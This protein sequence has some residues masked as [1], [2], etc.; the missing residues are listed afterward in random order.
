MAAE[1]DAGNAGSDCSVKRHSRCLAG[2]Q[3]SHEAASAGKR[4]RSFKKVGMALL[5]LGRSS[6]KSRNS[7]SKAD[8]EESQP[9][10]TIAPSA[11]GEATTAQ[12]QT[13]DALRSP[14]TPQTRGRGHTCVAHNCSA[15][16]ACTLRSAA[17]LSAAARVVRW[18]DGGSGAKLCGKKK[19]RKPF[20]RSPFKVA[21]ATARAV[22]SRYLSPIPCKYRHPRQETMGRRRKPCPRR[23][24]PA[25]ETQAQS[26]Q[27]FQLGKEQKK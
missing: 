10:E 8:D 17:N 18:S 20:P 27:H 5:T 13:Q 7:I 15:E 12:R 3:V 23:Q 1:T 25:S 22:A 9:A 16:V 26:A 24:R 4:N 21:D 11:V 14:E 6:R 2:C 19:P